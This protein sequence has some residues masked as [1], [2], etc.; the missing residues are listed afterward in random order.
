MAADAQTVTAPLSWELHNGESESRGLVIIR[1]E[2]VKESNAR[3]KFQIKSENMI[4][5]MPA[6]GG[7]F[8]WEKPCFINISRAQSDEEDC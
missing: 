6:L 3:C 7:L 5:K 4:A 1:A 2:N 8:K